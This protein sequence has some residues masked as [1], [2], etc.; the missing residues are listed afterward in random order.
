[1]TSA[2]NRGAT[3][4]GTGAT[5]ADANADVRAAAQCTTA[6]MQNSKQQATL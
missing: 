1:M 6:A 2:V 4:G 5:A 3:T